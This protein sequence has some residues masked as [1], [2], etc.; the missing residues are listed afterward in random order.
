MCASDSVNATL[1]LWESARV[2]RHMT[3]R[4]SSNALKRKCQGMSVKGSLEYMEEN[5]SSQVSSSATLPCLPC[6]YGP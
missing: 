2:L 4:V 6:H 1:K 5:P 3:Q